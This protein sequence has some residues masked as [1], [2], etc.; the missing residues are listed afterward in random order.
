MEYLITL[1]QAGVLEQIREIVEHNKRIMFET[2]WQQQFHT[3]LKTV[4]IPAK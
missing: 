1:S 4:L 2:D 3:N